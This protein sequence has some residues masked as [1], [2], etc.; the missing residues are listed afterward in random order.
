MTTSAEPNTDYKK[1]ARFLAE[2]R[3]CDDEIETLKGEHM[4]RCKNVRS[5][6]SSWF[7][8]IS[9]AGFDLTAIK[10]NLKEEKLEA[11]L[12]RHRNDAEEDT[13]ATAETIKTKLGEFAGTPLGAAAVEAAEVQS[14]KVVAMPK[15]RKGNKAKPDMSAENKADALDPSAEE[16]LRPTALKT[17]EAARKADAAKNLSGLKPLPPDDQPPVA[18]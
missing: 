11:A 6:R 13:L 15:G 10:F 2:V 12:E 7:D 1:L 3:K 5:R 17:R 14:A 16:D 18:H 4:S 9:D 8:Q